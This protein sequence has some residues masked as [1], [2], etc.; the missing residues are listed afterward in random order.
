MASG[1]E[2]TCPAYLTNLTSGK[3]LTGRAP[4]STGQLDVLGR[5][6]PDKDCEI[7]TRLADVGFAQV[8]SCIQY[9]Q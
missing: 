9:I 2:G 4:A 8:D 1:V 3:V 6:Y 5:Q 7:V